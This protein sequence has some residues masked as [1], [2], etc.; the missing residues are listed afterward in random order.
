MYHEIQRMNREGF[1]ISQISRIVLLDW[2]TVKHYLS[3]SEA[4]FDLFISG[5]P[6]RKK[7]LQPCEGFVHAKLKLYPDTSAAQMHDWLKE[8]FSHLEA[9]SPK[10]VFNFVVWVRQ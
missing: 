4:D 1:S 7:E 10:T 8:H 2:R 3:M 5:Q 9:V 6:E